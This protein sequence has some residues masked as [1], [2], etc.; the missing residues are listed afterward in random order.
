[1]L[2]FGLTN[3]QAEFMDPMHK[4]FHPYLDQFVV[5]FV[6]DKFFEILN[7]IYFACNLIPIQVTKTEIL[8]RYATRFSNLMIDTSTLNCVL[9]IEIR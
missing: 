7:L 6:D 2:P 1:M 8:R 4:V 3:A 9:K 5:V